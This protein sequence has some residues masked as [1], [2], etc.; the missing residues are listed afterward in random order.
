LRPYPLVGAVP[1]SISPASMAQD[2]HGGEAG[3]SSLV[4]NERMCIV[5]FH[6]PTALS[7]NLVAGTRRGV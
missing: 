3:K 1:V 4:M 2:R 5:S 7:H 6:I